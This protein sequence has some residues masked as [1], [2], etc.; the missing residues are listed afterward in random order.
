M[1]IEAG[2]LTDVKLATAEIE[3]L[4]TF[5]DVGDRTGFYM[6]YYAMVA[7]D[8]SVSLLGTPE[9]STVGKDEA[10]LQA[11][12]S[13]FSSPVGAAAYLSNRLLQEINPAYPGI[14][15]LSQLVAQAALDRIS[16]GGRELIDDDDFFSSAELAWD[17]AEDK[18]GQ[19][20]P[21]TQ[22]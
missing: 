16:N 13:S 1:G 15:T 11:K 2:M 12:I 14:Y 20:I 9:D 6:A 7:S 21:G 8:R 17:D 4:Q 10:S 5:L 3:Y 19:R 18:N 22:Y